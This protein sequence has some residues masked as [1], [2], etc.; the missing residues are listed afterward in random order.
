MTCTCSSRIAPQLTALATLSSY[1]SDSR[2][3]CTRPGEAKQ[4]RLEPGWLPCMGSH[5]GTSLQDC[6]A[7]HRWPQAAPRWDL[8]RNSTD[9]HRRS[10]WRVGYDYEPALKHRKVTS[11]TR[12]N[13]PALF[14]AIHILS[15]KIAMPSYHVKEFKSVHS[16]CNVFAF[17][18]ISAKYLEKK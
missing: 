11:S 7:W 18:S 12:C 6:S 15:K 3:Y 14:R 8:I 9:C 5:T 4:P 1:C 10:H 16:K 2:V 13:Q 17:S